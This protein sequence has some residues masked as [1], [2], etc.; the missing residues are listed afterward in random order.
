MTT[1][2]P[3]SELLRRAVQYIDDVRRDTPEKKLSQILDD[4][5][6]RFNLSPVDSE[7][8]RRLFESGTPSDELKKR[9]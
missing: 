6:M 7:A 5:G 1:I 4:A 2:M 3:Q 8:L 9:P